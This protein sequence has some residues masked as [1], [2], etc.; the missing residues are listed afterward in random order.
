MKHKYRLALV[1]IVILLIIATGLLFAELTALEWSND[2]T[3]FQV[4]LHV[5]IILFFF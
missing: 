3:S 4:I 1:A 2:E 5:L